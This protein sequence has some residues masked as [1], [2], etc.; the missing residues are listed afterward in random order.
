MS[1]RS[2]WGDNDMTSAQT[3]IPS[4]IERTA[5]T[6]LSDF[7]KATCWMLFNASVSMFCNQ[8]SLDTSLADVGESDFE[9][10]KLKRVQA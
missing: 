6:N 1:L 5:K 3:V 9:K 4:T 7:L 10:S 8:K 2:V